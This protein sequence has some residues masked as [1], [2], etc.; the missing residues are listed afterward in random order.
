MEMRKK[1]KFQVETDVTYYRRSSILG[2]K[3]KMEAY[4]IFVKNNATSRKKLWD[5]WQ[6]TTYHSRSSYKMKT[7]SIGHYKEVWSLD[8]L[9]KSQIF[10]EITQAQQKT[11]KMVFEVTRL[12][13]HIML[14]TRKNEH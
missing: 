7:I 3:M 4:C 11:S 10:L 14:Y 2:T 12:Q 13:L 5:L 6:E 9:W 1:G 8:W